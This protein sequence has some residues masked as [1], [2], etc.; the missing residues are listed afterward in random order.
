LVHLGHGW[1]PDPHDPADLDPRHER[2]E[3]QL[4][5]AGI[6]A[7][8]KV[9]SKLPAA[10]DLRKWC[11]PVQFQGSYN[12]CNAHVICGLLEYLENRAFGRSIVASSLFLFRAAQNLL[13]ERNNDG[14]YL[15][16]V[17]GAL[18]LIGV[19]PEKFW[20]YPEEL[21]TLAAP[22][23]EID[24]K[25]GQLI[26]PDPHFLAE[27]TAFCYAVAAN[28]EAITYYRLDRKAADGKPAVDPAAPD[29]PL[30]FPAAPQT[31]AA[32]WPQSLP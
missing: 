26:D 8:A 15:R 14:V 28:Y 1:R 3:G 9:E 13:G 24:P 2:V 22:Q 16:Q 18:K 25:T 12:T 11:S 21:G 5:K 17:M 20:P 30:A 19:P 10:V 27:P 31:P 6:A 29:S 32:P 23:P 4:E 7:A